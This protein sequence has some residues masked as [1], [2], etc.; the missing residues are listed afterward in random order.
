MGKKVERAYHTREVTGSSPVSPI[1][2][3][4]YIIR[5][6]HKKPM[7]KMVLVIVLFQSLFVMSIVSKLI[8]MNWRVEIGLVHLIIMLLCSWTLFVG[9]L[10]YISMRCCLVSQGG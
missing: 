1:N 3:S 4:P 5:S 9:V 8:I 7:L 6:Y 2:L 10:R